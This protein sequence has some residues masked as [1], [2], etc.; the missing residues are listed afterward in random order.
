MQGRPTIRTHVEVSVCSALMVTFFAGAAHGQVS[1]APAQGAGK[2]DQTTTSVAPVTVTAARPDGVQTSIDRRSYSVA[3]DLA[4]TSG[5]IADALKNIPSV[6]VSPT[7]TVTLRGDANVVIM[8]DGK[9]SNLLKGA[10]A[11]QILE[12][13]PAGSIARVEVLT[14]PSA[15]YS[16][17]G[18]AG[19]I[20]LVTKTVQKPG[21]AGTMRASVGTGGRAS[22]AAS[23]GYNTG[24]L[25]LSAEAS[26][27]FDS[28]NATGEDQRATLDGADRTLSTTRTTSDQRGSADQWNT[29][30]GADYDIDA[31]TRLGV[32]ARYNGGSF[33]ARDTEPATQFDA[34]GAQ[35]GAL[36]QH[37][38]YG[39]SR[40]TVA[41][42]GTAHR[43]FDG[44]GHELNASLS[45]E[46]TDEDRHSTLNA[47]A[48]PSSMPLYS[49]LASAN[50]MRLDEAK[51]D[52]SRPVGDVAT[53]KAGFDLRI[54]DNRYSAIG[55]RG[56]TS[57]DAVA[58]PTQTNL[59]LY[60]QTVDA[61]Y[62][63]Y[64]RRF[65]GLTVLAGMRIEDVEL[66]LNQ[67]TSAIM[68]DSRD[69]RGYPSLHLSHRLDDDQQLTFSFTRRVQR[70]RPEDLNPFVVATDPLNLRAGNANLRPQFTDAFELGYE[71]K[72]GSRFYAATL[73]YRSSQNGVT[74]V[75]TSQGNGIL[76]TTKANLASSLA[77]GLE[78]IGN[79][80]ITDTLSYSLSAN[81]YRS[82]I[83]ATP[84][85]VGG[86]IDATGT[87][88]TFSAGGRGT[89][90]WKPTAND[91]FQ[92]S[93]QLNA[94]R[95][96]PQGYY[97]PNFTSFLGYR[98]NLR[99]DL[100]VVVTVQDLFKTARMESHIATPILRDASVTRPSV[101]AIYVGLSWNFGGR[102]PKD[103]NID[104][105]NP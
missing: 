79:G 70:P 20:N 88:S 10:N 68:R 47:L 91:T 93:A 56:A 66:D 81:L 58:D 63:T 32:Q 92:L 75:V 51:A 33:S 9:P 64:E 86:I 98:H 62:V 95:L 34:S 77:E 80:K 35:L 59:F 54:D 73:Y 31:K 99:S 87:R 84:A 89:V 41:Y 61:A 69:F 8:I 57:A 74:D 90:T 29:R 101:Q 102:K 27:R 100:S 53:L 7:G 46:R 6:E 60:K 37:F 5:S 39:F 72:A 48:L 19:I 78:L 96:T 18:S 105:A 67:V 71:Y 24:S 97:D 43:A 3:T 14:N 45:S 28:Q 12:S 4:A 25:S 55:T 65:E 104:F 11:G 13:M 103:T 22:A 50:T 1:P 76:L 83:D 23:G 52:Y 85:D 21:A 36:L 2:P 49:N 42:Q 16:S 40:D 38:Q 94:K 17:D 30:L 26:A 44:D 15:Q 82:V